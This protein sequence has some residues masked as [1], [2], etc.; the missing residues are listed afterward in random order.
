MTSS[1][2]VAELLALLLSVKPA[3]AAT[4][5]LLTRVPV[6]LTVEGSSVP[7]IVYVTDVELGRVAVVDNVLPDPDA[8]PHAAPAPLG[9]QVHVT[10]VMVAGKVSVTNALVAV[11]GP[12]LVITTV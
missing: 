3:G 5:A 9:A 8:A 7:V 4:E 10:P 2:S 6:P 1:V 12:P 11:E